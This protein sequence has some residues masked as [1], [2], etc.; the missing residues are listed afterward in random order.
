MFVPGAEKG[1]TCGT[2]SG[3]RGKPIGAGGQSDRADDSFTVL[4]HCSKVC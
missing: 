2:V 1:A 3:E 4:A